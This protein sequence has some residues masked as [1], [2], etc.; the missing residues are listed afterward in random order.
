MG[1]SSSKEIAPSLPAAL[2]RWRSRDTSAPAPKDGSPIQLQRMGSM[3]AMHAANEAPAPR[4]KTE[5]Q[6]SIARLESG[7]LEEHFSPRALLT[8]CS[9]FL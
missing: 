9:I 8:S 6:A 7:Y 3:H 4:P 1:A 5:R 2:R